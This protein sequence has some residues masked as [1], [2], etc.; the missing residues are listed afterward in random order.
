MS[1]V[2]GRIDSIPE[3]FPI[4]PL[5]GA[6]LLPGGRLPLN[7]FEPRYLAMVDDALGS[8]RLIGMIQ[9]DYT[10]PAHETGPALYRQ[11]CLGRI[12]AFSETE[13]GRYLITLLG[14]VR[15]SIVEEAEMRRGYRRVHGDI[16][17]F[18]HDLAGGAPLPEPMTA[19]GVSRDRLLESLH[20]YFVATGVDANWDAIEEISDPALI[21]TLCMACPFTAIEKQALLEAPTEAERA[22]ALLALLEINGHGPHE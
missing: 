16:S 17:D 2:T 15:F 7:I 13:D 4:F 21:T 10:A 12:V 6:L 5:T 11:G 9:P 19:K 1:P 8:G 14:V 20:R 3:I 22:A 18:R